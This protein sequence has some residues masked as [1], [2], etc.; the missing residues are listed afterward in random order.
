MSQVRVVTC[1]GQGVVASFLRRSQMSGASQEFVFP[2]DEEIL[3]V[4]GIV[5]D[6]EDGD[7]NVRVLRIAG[8]GEEA[9]VSYDIVA[10]S[11]RFQLLREGGTV[12]DI[13]REGI[14]KIAVARV[15]GAAEISV[16][17]R[18]GVMQCSLVIQ[19][20]PCFSILDRMMIG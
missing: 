20:E 2:S 13:F 15:R 3:D 4:L 12:V 9:E 18:N 5:V 16:T 19:V 11:F 1:A 6:T 7:E 14:S 10:R 17:S 8:A